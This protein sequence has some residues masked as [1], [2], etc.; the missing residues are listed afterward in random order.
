MRVRPA[1]LALALAAVTVLGV[2]VM[3]IAGVGQNADSSARSLPSGRVLQPQGKTV[4]VGSFPVG[5][6]VTPD[7][8]FAWAIS[9]L[10]RTHQLRIVSVGRHAAVQTLT[11]AEATG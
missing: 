4:A 10:R 5:G 9:I 7:G 2:A 1:A 8:R 3:A 11:L 6:A